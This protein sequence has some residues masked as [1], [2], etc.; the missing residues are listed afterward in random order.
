M[1]KRTSKE[2]K[3]A[4]RK[5]NVPDK[6]NLFPYRFIKKQT[7]IKN[8]SNF[9]WKVNSGVFKKEMI[10]PDEVKESFQQMFN[11]YLYNLTHRK[12][13]R[14]KCGNT[15]SSNGVSFGMVWNNYWHFECNQCLR[16]LD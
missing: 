5:L 3:Y 6:K 12:R 4:C 14:C 8:Y 10:A 16:V 2:L 1:C 7:D 11:R 9:L 13:K 15:V